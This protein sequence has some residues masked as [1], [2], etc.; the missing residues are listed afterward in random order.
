MTLTCEAQFANVLVVKVEICPKKDDVTPSLT[1]D[2]GPLVCE[3]VWVTGCVH[4][5]VCYIGATCRCTCIHDLF[6]LYQ[7][8]LGVEAAVEGN[9]DNLFLYRI[10]IRNIQRLRVS[11]L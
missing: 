1:L 4:V 9:T 7:R 2:E 6:S 5:H 11:T 3:C 10:T 8:Q